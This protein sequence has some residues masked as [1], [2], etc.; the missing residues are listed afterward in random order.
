M[1][2]MST[3]GLTTLSWVLFVVFY[4]IRLFC[5][6]Q[7]GAAEEFWGH[8]FRRETG[9]LDPSEAMLWLVALVLNARI[10]WAMWK[11]Q[12]LSLATMWF[13][14]LTFVCFVLG[15]EEVSW[16]Q[17]IFGLVKPSEH[18]AEINA[19]HELNFHN[20][21]IS[22]LLG[23][24]PDSPWYP[25]FKNFNYL[26]N[27]AYYLFSCIVWVGLPWVQRRGWWAALETIPTPD[28]RIV[29]YFVASVVAYLIVDKLLWDVG[30]LFEFNLVSVYAL[31]ALDIW[32]RAAKSPTITIGSRKPDT[33][34]AAA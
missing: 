32:R 30:E 2:A 3:Q 6:A 28:R 15:G 9:L 21:N 4:A 26:L 25:K 19:Q 16:G 11:R 27:P 5:G 8:W 18:M 10:T 13:A 23:I 20:L 12:G 22:M 24:P 7:G 29:Y 34:H 14:G 31:A 33:A 1:T 17:H